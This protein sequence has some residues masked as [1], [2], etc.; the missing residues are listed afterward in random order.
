M[1]PRSSTRTHGGYSHCEEISRARYRGAGFRA[2]PAGRT[3]Q[4]TPQQSSP[5]LWIT[6][7]GAVAPQRRRAGARAGTFSAVRSPQE[8]IFRLRQEAGNLVRLVL[9]PHARRALQ[10]PLAG[11]PD[12]AVVARSLTGTPYAAEVERLAERI[13]Q[14]HFPLM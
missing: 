9:P 5:D 4:R 11:L 1:V 12:A 6:D 3:C 10:P 8:I 13:L 7:A 14:H 2:L